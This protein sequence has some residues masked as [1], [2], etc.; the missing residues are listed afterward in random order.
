MRFA[1]ALADTQANL[2][3]IYIHILHCYLC[4][5]ACN[6][7]LMSIALVAK[8]NMGHLCVVISNSYFQFQM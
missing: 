7:F 6:N 3:I 4:N 8:E 5:N 1:K 2:I